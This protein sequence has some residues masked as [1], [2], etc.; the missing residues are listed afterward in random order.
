SI[1]A[2]YDRVDILINSAGTN[3]PTRAWHSVTM[4]DF[5]R[6]VDV[7]LN[8]AF[9]CISTVLPSMRARRNGTIINVAFVGRLLS[10]TPNRT[11][12]QRKE[13]RNDRDDGVAQHGRVRERHSC[14]CDLTRGDRNRNPPDAGGAT[15]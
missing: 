2:R 14:L 5:K 7:N 8:G 13:A 4:P 3:V 11:C 1:L 10:D 12:L 15:F 9:N 6:G